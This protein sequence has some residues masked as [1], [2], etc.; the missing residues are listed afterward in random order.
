VPESIHEGDFE[1]ALVVHRRPFVL[2]RI[3]HLFDRRRVEMWS[4]Q[5]EPRDGGDLA[6]IRV[7]TRGK[8]GEIERLRR[9]LENVVDVID[10]SL[11]APVAR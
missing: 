9:A 1:M 11:H 3:A 7:R 6:D 4:V 5:V 8:A 10:A 2:A